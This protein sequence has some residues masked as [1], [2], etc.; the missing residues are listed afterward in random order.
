M[1]G[2]G[3]GDGHEVFAANAEFAGD[4]DAG[5]VGEG[6]A[7]L[8]DGFAAANKIRM[9]VAVEADAV[10]EAMD[11]ELVAGAKAGG[12][13]DGAGSIVNRAREFSGLGSGESG[14]LCVANGGVGALHFFCW[15]AQDAGAGDIGF[16]AFDKAAAVDK[17][18]IPLL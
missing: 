6:H 4:V 2:A 17:D 13:D 1:S 5:F 9:L 3:C 14:I 11:E 8:E 12:S 7:G 15:L 16:V 18:H 10:A